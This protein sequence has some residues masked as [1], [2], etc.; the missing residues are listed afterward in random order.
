MGR[1]PEQAFFQRRHTDGQQTHEKM[2]NTAN[3]QGK[4]T[5]TTMRYHFTPVRMATIK[6]AGNNKCWQGCGEKGTLT[7]IG[8]NVNQRSHCGKQYE[9]PQKI[10]NRIII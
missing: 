9:F 5:R 10:K 3:H 6:N 1:E 4:Q 7:T 2:L 8:R